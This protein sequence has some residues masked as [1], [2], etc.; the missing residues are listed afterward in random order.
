[1]NKMPPVSFDYITTQQYRQLLERD[2]AEMHACLRADAWKASM[3]LAGS[4]I[5]AVLVEHLEWLSPSGEEKRIRKLV[6]G[7]VITECASKGEITETTAKLCSAVKDYRNLIHPGKVVRDSV[8]APDQNNAII[9]T[10]LVGRIVGEVAS[11][12]RKHGGLT[13]EQLLSKLEKDNGAIAIFP[14]LLKDITH[15]EKHRLVTEVL[16]VA[17][18]KSK[19]FVDNDDFFDASFPPR[20]C[21]AYRL[22]TKESPE[23][24]SEAAKQFH[25][26][27]ISGDALE[28][29]QHR[30]A[31]F[32]PED[33]AHLTDAMRAVVIDHLIGIMVDQRSNIRYQEFTG[34]TPFLTSS[35]LF[36]FLYPI[37]HDLRVSDRMER[38]KDFLSFELPRLPAELKPEVK[39][40]LIEQKGSPQFRRSANSIAYLDELIEWIDFPF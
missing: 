19:L 17:Y 34:I 10:A 11:A 3:V 32:N 38:A 12:R 2:L 36:R 4:L 35:S 21:T 27:I 9:V 28:I 23:L 8:A 7:D 24:S 18:A 15:K 5:E 30:E 20:I 26:L 25:S 1:M 6:L 22:T 29:A 13:A 40:F 37:I 31:F 16:P 39:E 33:L 14:H